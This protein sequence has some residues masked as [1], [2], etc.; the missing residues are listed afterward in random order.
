MLARAESIEEETVAGSPG[1]V[2]EEVGQEIL[3]KRVELLSGDRA[4]VVPPDRA[5]GGGVAHDELVLGRPAGVLAGVDGERP[6]RRDAGLAT[7]QGVLVQLRRRRVPVD[8][9][10]RFD[11]VHCEARA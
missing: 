11:A 9:A 2:V 10:E 5:L 4:V 1:L 6:A 3:K 8:G 7:R